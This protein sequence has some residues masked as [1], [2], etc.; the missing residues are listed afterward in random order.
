[1]IDY[2]QLEVVNYD[3]YEDKAAIGKGKAM[4]D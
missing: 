4:M 1:M 2:E 3:T